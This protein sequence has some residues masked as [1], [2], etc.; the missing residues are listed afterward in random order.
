MSAPRVIRRV[1]PTFSNH[2]FPPTETMTDYNTYLDG[3]MAACRKSVQSPPSWPQY[4]HVSPLPNPPFRISL[5]KPQH[6]PVVSTDRPA[7]EAA[8]T[9]SKIQHAAAASR[10][11]VHE[12]L[13]PA[14]NAPRSNVFT[15]RPAVETAETADTS[16]KLQHAAIASQTDDHKNQTPAENATL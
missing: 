13:P 14:L 12:N 11:D 8:D 7:V 16:G 4:P 2:L 1:S 5:K 15:D 9:S 3:L 6:R 10:S